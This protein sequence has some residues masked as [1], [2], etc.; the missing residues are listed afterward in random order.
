MEGSMQDEREQ[1]EKLVSWAT[2]SKLRADTLQIA[3]AEA[4][5]SVRRLQN[6][7]ATLG[8]VATAAERASRIF[9]DAARACREAEAAGEALAAPRPLAA[10]SRLL[11]R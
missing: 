7:A 11:S 5:Q 4:A 3:A 9:D 10:G 6:S 1:R 2:T 8:V